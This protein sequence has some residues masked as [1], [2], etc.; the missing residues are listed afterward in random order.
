MS[1]MTLYGIS[2]CDKVRAARRW[3]DARQLDY[4]FHD[5]RKDGCEPELLERLMQRFSHDQL[6]NKRS[7]TWRG[8]SPAEQQLDEASALALMQSHPALIKRPLLELKHETLLGFDPDAW[9]QRLLSR[10]A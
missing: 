2:N 8:L 10:D 1:H 5:L 3:L 6:I 7:T 9:E 4:R